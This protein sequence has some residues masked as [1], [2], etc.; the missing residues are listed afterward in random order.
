MLFCNISMSFQWKI[1]GLKNPRVVQPRTIRS[2]LM[3]QL[4]PSDEELHY[5]IMGEYNPILGSIISSPGEKSRRP[6]D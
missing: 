3:S 1:P 6:F 2:H 5:G 4:C